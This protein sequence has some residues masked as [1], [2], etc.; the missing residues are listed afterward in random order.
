VNTWVLITTHNRH[1]LL[2]DLLTDVDRDRTVIVDHQSHPPIVQRCA[3]VIRCDCPPNISHLWNLGLNRIDTLNRESAGG[4]VPYNVLVCND[5]L[6]IPP[7][8]IDAL[9]GA[10][11]AADAVVSF[12]D[13]HGLLKPGQT[14]TLNTPGPVNLFT[15]MTGY[16]FMLRGER[17]FRA[18]ERLV[19]WY[20]DDD[21]EWRAALAGGVVR[22]GG[23]T[24]THLNPNGSM[25][26][27]ALAAQTAMD[28]E[29]FIQKWGHPPW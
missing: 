8:T 4:D 13:V 19:W 14:V 24:V 23:V 9:A 18:D 10:L 25:I 12:P 5:D 3:Q 22:V 28:R 16:C 27:P 6:R 7:E 2:H 20:G 29:V 15:R 17:G 26:N 21:L 11:R 1:S